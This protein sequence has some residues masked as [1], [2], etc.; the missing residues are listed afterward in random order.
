ML[1]LIATWLQI[2]VEIERARLTKRLAKLREEEGN[3]SEAAEI[4]QEVAVVSYS[5]PAGPAW[6][7]SPHPLRPN[8]FNS[9]R[10]PTFVLQS[11]QHGTP[12]PWRLMS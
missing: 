7:L 10:W 3:I 11:I 5:A 12:M 2:Y 9:F 6:Q 1:C 8:T 4:L